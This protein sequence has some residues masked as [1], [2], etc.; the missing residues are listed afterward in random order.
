MKR[1]LSILSVLLVFSVLSFAQSTA[2]APK[3]EHLTKSQL[4]A[5]IASAKTP[6]E[7]R[8]IA[9]YFEAKSQEYLAESKEHEQML[10]SYRQNPLFQSS[11][12]KTQTIGHCEYLASSLRNAS[13]KEHELA[14]QHEAMAAELDQK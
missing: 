11:K 5:L 13:A 12:F 8:Q 14:K 4:H 6:S 2:S 7:H 1:T 9:H 3:A 10:E